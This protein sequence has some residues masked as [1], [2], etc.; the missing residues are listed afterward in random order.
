MPAATPENRL[1]RDWMDTERFSNSPALANPVGG[2][3]S[4]YP[5]DEGRP[6]GAMDGKSHSTAVVSPPSDR[7]P[8]HS[9][10]HQESPHC[11]FS[12]SLYMYLIADL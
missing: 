9:M 6:R 12:A 1:Q 5:S 7:A 4:H 10:L 3:F 11:P 8:R 2:G